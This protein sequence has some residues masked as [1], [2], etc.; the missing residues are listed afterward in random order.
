[1]SRAASL[2]D[3]A[4]RGRLLKLSEGQVRL[5]RAAADKAE[6]I[7]MVGRLMVDCAF[8][9]PGCADDLPPAV[10]RTVAAVRT[11]VHAAL[12]EAG[13]TA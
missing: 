2:G 1:M 11:R 4:G 5:G 10:L 12:P 13:E 6:T 7:R 9:E 3:D 8:V